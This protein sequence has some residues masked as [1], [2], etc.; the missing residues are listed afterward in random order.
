[1]KNY[2]TELSRKLQ[3]W[4]VTSTLASRFREQVWTRIERA[5]VPDVSVLDAW[6]AW[7]AAAFARPAFAVAY[8]TV[9]VIAGLTLGFAQASAQKADWDRQL[10]GRYVQAV[11]PYQRAP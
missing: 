2:D 3:E 5:E 11:D 7:F 8:V 10:E 1:M 6:R 9:L 4:T